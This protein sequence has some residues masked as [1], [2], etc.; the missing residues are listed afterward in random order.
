MQKNIFLILQIIFSIVYIFK[1]STQEYLMLKFIKINPG[2]LDL[3]SE[4]ETVK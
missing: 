3:D 4:Q 2:S 1:L